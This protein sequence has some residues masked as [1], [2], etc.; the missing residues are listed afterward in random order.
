MSKYVTQ[1]CDGAAA[2][3]AGIALKCQFGHVSASFDPMTPV[4]LGF[5]SSLVRASQEC[6]RRV[7]CRQFGH[8]KLMVQCTAW[9]DPTSSARLAQRIQLADGPKALSPRHQG[10]FSLFAR[11]DVLQGLHGTHHTTEGVIQR[12]GREKQPPPRVTQGGKEA[13]RLK[14][15]G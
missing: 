11:A 8:A 3:L 15:L 14:A 12:C 5:T 9:A 2:T 6:V 1:M 7:V 13:F 4:L 10:Q